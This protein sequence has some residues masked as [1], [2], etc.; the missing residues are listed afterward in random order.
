MQA[1]KIVFL[2]DIDLQHVTHCIAKVCTKCLLHSSTNRNRQAV[3]SKASRCKVMHRG[4]TEEPPMRI[5]LHTRQ[6]NVSSSRKIWNIQP[7]C[8]MLQSCALH[9]VEC[10]CIAN[11]NWK[12]YHSF[13][14][15]E[16]IIKV[17]ILALE[18]PNA[19]QRNC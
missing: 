11:A 14:C 13:F 1:F 16:F 5:A 2:C 3:N 18:H 10:A 6:C 15:F 19:L 17:L 9:L 12:M 8:D 7:N 4:I